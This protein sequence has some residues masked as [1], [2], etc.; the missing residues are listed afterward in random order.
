MRGLGRALPGHYQRAA[1]GVELVPPS[2]NHNNAT[3]GG[4]SD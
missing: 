3:G 4:L 2:N 1:L